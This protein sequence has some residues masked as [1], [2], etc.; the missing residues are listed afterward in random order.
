MKKEDKNRDIQNNWSDF[1]KLNSKLEI[2]WDESKEDI[3]AKMA[4]KKETPKAEVKT[5]HFWQQPVFRYAVAAVLVLFVAV[6]AIAR[7]Y[8][9]TYETRHGE[10]L[11][12]SLPDGSSVTLNA[13]S[14]VVFHPYWWSFSRSLEFEGE[15]FFE[16]EKGSNFSVSSSNG[17]TTV[18]GT[19]F[20]IFARDEDYRVACVAGKVKVEDAEGANEVFLTPNEKAELK[21][22]QLLKSEINTDNEIAWINNKFVFSSTPIREVFDEIERQYGVVIKSDESLDKE[23][24]GGFSR[25]DSLEDVLDRVCSSFS[26]KF[27]EESTGVFYITEQ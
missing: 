14:S 5:I 25:E 16:V 13:E 12:V 22:G 4:Q 23:F 21:D 3:W 19:S 18:M 11:V 27:T 6:G 20:N 1:E 15:G 9:S 26:L 10:H 2:S 24:G 7:F 8:S 17:T